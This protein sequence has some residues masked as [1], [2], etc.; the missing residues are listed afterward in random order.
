MSR[1]AEVYWLGSTAISYFI[2]QSKGRTKVVGHYT[3]TSYIGP[4]LPKGSDMAAPLQAAIQYL[5]DNGTYEKIVTKW[6]LQS[7]A[8]KKAPLNPTN[9]QQ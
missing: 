9:A 5:M 7:G 3:D 1:R 2:A 6:G 8:V 4:A